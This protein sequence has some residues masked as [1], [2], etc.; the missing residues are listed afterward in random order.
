M[1]RITEQQNDGYVPCLPR[2]QH[3]LLEPS[4]TSEAKLCSFT[5]FTVIN[6]WSLIITTRYVNVKLHSTIPTALTQCDETLAPFAIMRRGWL[7]RLQEAAGT[8][9]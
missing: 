4:S 5:T 7:A 3:S 9:Y 8:G 6:L 1:A 2:K